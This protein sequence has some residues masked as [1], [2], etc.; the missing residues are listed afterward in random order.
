MALELKRVEVDEVNA[1]VGDV[2]SQDVEVVTE[3]E[4][5]GGW[6][7]HHWLSFRVSVFC[8]TGGL[9]TIIRFDAQHR[10]NLNDR[11]SKLLEF[12]CRR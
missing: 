2:L 5:V 12:Q 3:V 11:F 7:G 4:V 6:C 8:T 1:L 9:R 10:K